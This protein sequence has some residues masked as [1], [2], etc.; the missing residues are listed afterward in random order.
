MIERKKKE[1]GGEKERRSE[2]RD[3]DVEA[4]ERKYDEKREKEELRKK[5]TGEKE[6]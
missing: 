4:S 1:V 2:G 6:A 3:A 5:C